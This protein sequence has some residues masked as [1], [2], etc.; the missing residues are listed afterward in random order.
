MRMLNPLSHARTSADAERYKVEPYVVAADV[1]AVRGN[2]GRGGWTW[3]TGSAS[4]SYRVALEGVLGF[5]KV[6]DL[7]RIDPCIPS[8]WDGFTLEYRYGESVYAIEIQNPEHVSGGVAALIVDGVASTNGH[9]VLSHDGMR[10]TVIVLL[11]Q[12]TAASAEIGSAAERFL[13]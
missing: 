11:G 2:E 10:H 8:V 3:Y 4:W 5:E 9:V 13:H 7:L 1:Y 12:L 6:G